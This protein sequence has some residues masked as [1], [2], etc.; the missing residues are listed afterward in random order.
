M[1]VQ[2]RFANPV[3]DLSLPGALRKVAF[4][5]SWI[6]AR[7]PTHEIQQL[8][9]R[10]PQMHLGTR[11]SPLAARGHQSGPHRVS[12]H[13]EQRVPGVLVVQRN[14]VEARLPEVPHASQSE[15][16]AT[17]VVAVNALH[18]ARQTVLIM[19]DSDKMDMIVHQAVSFESD[20]VMRQELRQQV[21]VEAPVFVAKEDR[22]PVIPALRNV[23]RGSWNNT[24][25]RPWHQQLSALKPQLLSVPEVFDPV[26]PAAVVT[27][28]AP[29]GTAL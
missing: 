24:A 21:Q 28:P 26:C 7:P 13:V 19:R 17:C 6:K 2:R 22:L 9:F 12:L 16:Q 23:M 29:R 4:P 25:L 27:G 8:A 14:G 10:H 1:S 18:G 15:V 20:P 5:A 11:P 3:F